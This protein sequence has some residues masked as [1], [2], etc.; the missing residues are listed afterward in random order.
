[1]LALLR[2]NPQFSRLWISQVV[3]Q[4]GDWLDRMACIVL[5]GH[6]G[7]SVGTLG[8]LFGL[9]LALRLL[10]ASLLTPFAGPVSDRLP[11]RA[12]M[13]GADLV[14]ALIVLGF[15]LVDEPRKLPWLYALIALQMSFSVFFDVA[16]SAAVPD[17]VRRED[18]HDANAISAATWS[19]M[20]GLG[21]VLGGTLVQA[22]GVRGVFVI[23]SLS[24][25]ASAIALARM[26]LPPVPKA[27]HVFRWSEFL[28]LRDLKRGWD[29]A[30]ERSLGVMLFAKT[31][32]GAAGGF[33]VV[34]SLAPQVRHAQGSGSEA[35]DAA[36][37]ATGMLYSA[38]GLGT[39]LGPWLSRR[40]LGGS[41]RA[42]R[43]QIVCGFGVAVVGYGLFGFTEDLAWECL[44]VAFAH[45][46]G[47]SIWIASTVFW[48]RHTDEAFRGRVFAL[49][50]FSMN[51]AFGLGGMVAG[52]TFDRTHSI[53]I[54][55]WVLCGMVLVL[56]GLWSVLAFRRPLPLEAPGP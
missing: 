11:R 8:A 44:W 35:M 25:V 21:G 15:L 10:P 24:Y 5:I 13:I 23:D 45:L 26:R 40:F 29:H 41:D 32:W 4:A 1:M 56:G 49:E 43:L 42:L 16:R 39:G 33:L 46:G 22:V 18:L 53:A 34:L 55:T 7:G 47:A 12:L 19:I 38:R 36:A 51:I 3:S 17:T 6:L 9:E 2:R 52:L 30:R 28:L 20:L 50:Y 14:R 54:T 31:F 48:Q 27:A 37:F